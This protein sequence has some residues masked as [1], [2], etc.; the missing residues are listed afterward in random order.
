MATTL[1][2]TSQAT[3]HIIRYVHHPPREILVLT[4]QD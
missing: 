4:E 2:R 1:A 3:V